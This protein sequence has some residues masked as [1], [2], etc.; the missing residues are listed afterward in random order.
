MVHS[1]KRKKKKVRKVQRK[2]RSGTVDVSEAETEWN[3][4]G[5]VG[6]TV[7]KHGPLYNVDVDAL[8]ERFAD[9]IKTTGAAMK[10]VS[11]RQKNVNPSIQHGKHK[12]RRI[13]SFTT[14]L[15]EHAETQRDELVALNAIYPHSVRVTKQGH[16][17][18]M[19]PQLKSIRFTDFNDDDDGDYENRMKEILK[20]TKL[21]FYSNTVRSKENTM[22]FSLR[23]ILINFYYEFFFDF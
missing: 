17:D 23:S 15:Q 11:K 10:K 22:Y 6:M 13:G 3:K 14:V 2:E 21:E 1:E 5:A 7:S 16:L 8:L 19:D 12:H 20:G 18:S 4:D 9:D